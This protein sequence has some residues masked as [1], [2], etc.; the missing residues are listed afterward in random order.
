M[1]LPQR[2][3]YTIG[4]II[5]HLETTPPLF[6][7][8]STTGKRRRGSRE[9]GETRPPTSASEGCLATAELSG[10]SCGTICSSAVRSPTLS[11]CGFG[12][13][14]EKAGCGL[15]LAAAAAFSSEPLPLLFPS[16]PPSLPHTAQS[17]KPPV[18][19]L[20]GCQHQDDVTGVLESWFIA[21]AHDPYPSPGGLMILHLLL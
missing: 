15:L 13:D 12:S 9:G 8:I 21:H 18:Q 5:E 3:A 1:P 20:R 4:K 14:T 2:S 19:T 6:S 7:H 10:E 16:P 17:A 11:S